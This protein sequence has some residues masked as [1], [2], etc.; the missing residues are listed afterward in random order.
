M[1]NSVSEIDL[2]FLSSMLICVKSSIGL[3]RAG[4]PERRIARL[5]FCERASLLGIAIVLVLYYICDVFYL[6]TGKTSKP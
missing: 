3:E 1:P 5:A 2:K 6:R 4:V